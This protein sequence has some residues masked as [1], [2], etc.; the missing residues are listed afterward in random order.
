MEKNSLEQELNAVQYDGYFSIDG[1]TFSGS[2]EFKWQRYKHLNP[3]KKFRVW[4]IDSGFK[5]YNEN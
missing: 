3:S 2:L 5:L 4:L 1:E